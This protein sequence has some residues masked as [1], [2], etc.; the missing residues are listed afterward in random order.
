VLTGHAVDAA[1]GYYI[2]PLVT[3]A[4]AVLVL[5]E[6]LRRTQWVALGI[7]AVAVVV[8]T[9][10]VGGLPWIALALATTF[11]VYGLIK[12]RVGRSVPAVTSLA[13]ETAFLAPA[14]LAYLLWLGAA[15]S[16]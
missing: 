7:G 12:N 14:A 16:G 3:V 6:R 15:G 8:I 10:G 2:N 11:G 1:L 13:V 9:A 4:L 5:G